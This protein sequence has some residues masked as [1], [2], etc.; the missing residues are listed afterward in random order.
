[1]IGVPGPQ[2]R[3]PVDLARPSTGGRPTGMKASGVAYANAKLAI[4]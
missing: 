1:M 4:L 2:W 3:D